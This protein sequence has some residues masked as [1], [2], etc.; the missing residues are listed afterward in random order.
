MIPRRYWSPLLEALGWALLFVGAQSAALLVLAV[1]YL[2]AQISANP[3]LLDNPQALETL[4]TTRLTEDFLMRHQSAVL[5]LSTALGL[6][7]LFLLRRRLSPPLWQGLYL[8]SWGRVPYALLVP[9]G[10]SLQLFTSILSNRILALPGMEGVAELFEQY[11]QAVTGGEWIGLELLA[12]AVAGPV[13]EEIFFRGAVLSALRRTALPSWLCVV[14]QALLFGLIHG[15]PLQMG[16]AALIGLA[17]G[18]LTVFTGSVWPGVVIHAVFNAAS[19]WPYALTHALTGWY[20]VP[21]LV[22]S[23][24][25][26]FSCLVLIF[27]QKG[28]RD[29]T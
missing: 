12:V 11:T 25:T 19:Y 22:I 9:L 14:G 8:H 23:G 13:C 3:H 10:I 2:A 16:Y 5:L 1:P 27:S 20:W 28:T 17:L 4:L 7:V 26:V 15:V 21:L 18:F 24:V 6:G 29:A